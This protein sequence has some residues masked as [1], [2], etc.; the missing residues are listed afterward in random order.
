MVLR[1]GWWEIECD[2]DKTAQCYSQ[3]AL[4]PDCQCE[5]C[6]N[7]MA[8]LDR[9]FPAMSA[10]FIASLGID[11]RKPAELAHYN[12]EQSG[13]HYT[14]DWFHLVGEI[15]SGADAWIATGENSWGTA[16]EQLGDEIEFGFTRHL[17]LLRDPFRLHPVIQLE[18]ATRVPWVIRAPE[19]M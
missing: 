5:Y 8:A 4:G 10:A 18:F 12:R 2:S 6:R 11:V 7:F 3:L 16:F 19:P 1:I 9:A 15:R 13:L 17:A 14:G